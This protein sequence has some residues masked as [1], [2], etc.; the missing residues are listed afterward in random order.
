LLTR[1][2][3]WRRGNGVT[4]AEPDLVGPIRG[5]V[6]GVD[7]LA[8]Q[9][10]AV[11]RQQRIAPPTTRRG[12]GP[13]LRRLDQT[14]VVLTDINRQLTEA[15]GRGV[16]VSSAGEW[17]LD[18]YYIV[19]EHMREIRMSLPSRYYQEL[20]KLANGKLAGYPRVY[21]L[22]IELIGHTEG[23]LDLENIALFTGEYQRITSL[24]L[25]EL[26][27]IPT[28][29]RLGLVEN[30][31]RMA[32]RTVARLHEVEAADAAVLTLRTASQLS[33]EAL[34]RALSDFV[35]HHPPLTP[36][37]VAR[38]LSQIRSYQTNFTPL[39][40]LE[41]WIAEDGPSAE[42]AVTRS[43]RRVAIT[44][45]TITNSIQSLRMIARLDWN[46]FVESQSATE[47]LLREDPAGVYGGMAFES[48]DAYRHVV[49]HVAKDAK[50]E[51]E[52]VAADALALAREH[53]GDPRLGHVGYWLIETAGRRA[54]EARAGYVPDAEE[55][56]RRWALRHPSVI[57]FG[58]VMLIALLTIW[59]VFE[60]IP[61]GTAGLAL[62]LLLLLAI[63]ASEV[64]V[65][66]VNQLVTTFLPPHILAKLDYEEHGIPPEAQTAV[67]IPTL[68]GSVPVVREALEHLE[69]QY[70]ANPDPQL[71][72]AL[73]SDFTDARSETCPE[74]AQ[75][76]DAAARGVSHLNARYRTKDGEG[77]FLLLHRPRRWNPT[78]GVWMGW[79]R[80]RGK[81]AEFNRYLRGGARDAFSLVAGDANG[82]AA[83]RYVITLDSDTVLPRGA[84]AR[85]VG[86]MAHPLNRAEY[87][88][89]LGRVV[90]GYGILQPRVGVALT[91]AY[92]SKFAAIHSGHPG[93]DPYTTA[94]SDVYQDLY[95]EGSFTGKGIYDVDAFEAATHGRFPENTL[96]SHDLIEGTYSRA[97]L[98]TDIELYDDYPTR[99]LAYTRRKHRWIR[100][101]WQ[102]VRWLRGTVPGPDGPEPNRL[103]ALSRW[104]I[105]DN[106]RRSLLEIAQVVLLIA[107]W[108]LLPGSPVA[109]SVTVILFI[110]F[111]WIF[112]AAL[113]LLQPPLDQSWRAYYAAVGRDAMAS[114]EQLWLAVTF[115]PH[116]AAVSADAIVRTLIR[117]TVTH[118][119]LLEWQTASQV[120]RAMRSGSD[121][122][123]FRRMWPAVTFALA[124]MLVTIGAVAT[125]GMAGESVGRSAAL[126]VG[127]VPLALLW[128]LS[129]RIAVALSAPAI[130][131]EVK[132]SEGERTRALR[133]AKLHWEFFDHFVTAEGN[134]LAP[135]NFQEEPAPVIAARTSPTN[136]GL[137]LLSLV[138][139]YDLGFIARVDMIERLEQVFR[140]LERMQRYRGHFYNWYDIGTLHVLE[141]AYVSTVDSGNLAGHFIALKQ[142]C[143]QII[144]SL[145]PRTLEM[146][147]PGRALATGVVAAAPATRLAGTVAP[148]EDV[149]DEC[150]RLRAIADRAFAYAMEM[151]FTF[152]FDERRKLFSIGYLTSANSFDNSFY[153]LLASE[154][155]LAS[156]VAIAKGDVPVEHWFHLGRSLT[157]A[158]GTRAL[159]SWSGSMFEYLMPVLITQSY[160]FTLLD[161]TYHGAVRRQIAYGA[162]RHVP[163][164]VSESA[165]NMRDRNQT[166]Q[167]RA[168]GVPDLALKR[169]LSKDLVVAPYATMLALL[170]APHQA[171]RNLSTLEAAGALGP[172]GFRDAVDYTRPEP[173]LTHATV[174]AYMAHHIGMS[175]V[176][177]TNA[178]ERQV[179]QRRFHADPVVRST[180]LVLQ[181]RIPRRLVV[182]QT[183]DE[184]AP[185]PTIPTEAGKP[186]VREMMTAHTAQPR[187]ALLGNVPYTTMITNAGGG[188]S[189]YGD[190]VV[191]RWRRDTTRDNQGEWVYLKDLTAGRVW[192][193]AYQPVAV[194][195]DHYRVLLAPD[196]VEFFRRDGDVE[197]RMEVVV[198]S[199]DAAEV[200]RVTVT[201]RSLLPRD[202]ELTSYS[203]IVLQPL[204]TDRQHPAFG[205]LF[206]ETEWIGANSAILAT[207]RPRSSTDR[208]YWAVHVVAAGAERIGEV[209]YE[210]DRARFIGRGKSVRHPAALEENGTLSNSVGAPLDPIFSLRV[211]L[212]VPPGKSVPVSFTTFVA[213]TRE[214]AL[215]LADLYDDPFSARR[216]LDLSWA[217]AQAELRDL[218]MAPGDAAVYQQL[219]GYLMYPHPRLVSQSP[220]TS[221]V[222]RGQQSLWSLGVSGDHPIML[223]SI[224]TADGLPSV[225]QLLQAHH[226]W[227]LKGLTS[228]LVILNERPP[229]YLQELNDAITETVMASTESGLLDRP[230]GVFV[231]RTDLISAEDLALLRAMARMQVVC[232]GVGLGSLL[233]FPDEEG[234]VGHPEAPVP[235]RYA[236]RLS[237]PRPAP[238]TDDPRI[239]N[240]YG[241]FNDAG[242]YELHLT[243][244][245][246]PPAPWANVIANP[247]GGFLVTESGSSCTW[248][249]NSFFYRLTPWH[250]DPV[251]DPCSDSIY[252]RDDDTGD[253]WTA[254]PAPIREMTPYIVRHGFG[255][256]VFDHRHD[257]VHTELR[258]G[259]AADEPVKIAH[260]LVTNAGA[261]AK[262]LTVTGYVEWV[263]GVSRDLTQSYLHTSYDTETH[264]LFG[265]NFFD[266]QWAG[267][268]AF[269]AMSG[270]VASF[271]GDRREF[272]GRNGTP[273]RPAALSRAGLG[274][275]VGQL[276]DP[277]GALQQ[278]L[279]I[280]AGETREVIVLLGAAGSVDDVRTLIRK[281]QTV[282]TAR[283]ELERAVEAWR[284]RLGVVR[285]RTPDA[286]FD[287]IQNGWLLYQALSC[288]MWGRTALYQSSGAYG[289]R[290]QL[291][292]SMAFLYA[293]QGVAREHILRCAHRQFV[294]G[295]VQHWWH[296]QTG[297]GVRTRI[298]D[299]L[300]WLPYVVCHYVE[301]TGDTALLDE[302]VPYITMR[303]LAPDEQEVYDQPQQSDQTGSVYDH[304]VRA[305]R[306]ACTAGRHGLPL[307]GGG[308]WNDGFNRVGIGGQGESVWLAWFL[309]VTLERTAA[310]ADARGDHATATEFRERSARYTQAVETSSWDG[311]WYVRAYYDDGYPLGSSRSDEA[312]IDS[313]AQS[314]ALLS[315]A[316]Q[317]ARATTAMASLDAQLV[318]EDA[319]LIMLLTPA[320]DHTSHDP[321]YIKGYLPGVRENGAQYTHAATWA[322]WATVLAGRGTRAFELFR[323]LNPLTHSGDA[324]AVE[325]YKVEPYVVVADLYTAESHLG[326]GGWT[327]YTGS[328]SWLYRAGLEAI[329][330]F[331]RRADTLRMNPCIPAAWDGFEVE[332][333]HGS[334][335]YHVVVRNPDHVE[336]GVATVTLDGAAVGDGT[337]PL[338]DD[339]RRHEVVVTMGAG[340]PGAGSPA[341]H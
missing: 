138:S 259:M 329:L 134:W 48:R 74:D 184:D 55:R 30:I 240:G 258:V 243:G 90:R 230:G 28:M 6:L 235:P 288:R 209:T 76:L 98:V 135:D 234:Y 276:V 172:F 244:T 142:A 149:G 201:N 168:F 160:P 194:D 306:R 221:A 63:P 291:Q 83:T 312:K 216:A 317:P 121:R 103:S 2:L 97:G 133:Y 72:Y 42:E 290:D 293:E 178:L 176:A 180:E 245:E 146:E 164:G 310:V 313:I 19:Q 102:I 13:L 214:R 106:L 5:E 9:A 49:E 308:D 183:G 238:R 294:E 95:G 272:I 46:A 198:S 211:R 326:R 295:D 141:P 27:A 88:E 53:Q 61:V 336:R 318:R 60:A 171:L 113:A 16:D 45:V 162:E 200:R 332:Y 270:E 219:A 57:Y 207:R 152:L 203:E 299:D 275:A 262:R 116:Q 247:R 10:R 21:E 322:V 267:Q 22:A 190:I 248:A 120:E 109:W 140:S 289:F 170:V 181:E 188:F 129:P 56:A 223:A 337:V 67:V 163:W 54:L 130:P 292:D 144:H 174:G 213:E 68:F 256:S 254:T 127:T 143:I 65:T 173:G 333:A 1:L 331:T 99:Y 189:R 58:T 305:L 192:S 175:L 212:R 242:E 253:V 237:G 31:R 236:R 167:Y 210:T 284:R 205:N 260:L 197:T 71:R 320:F 93:V 300:V 239:T 330:G 115:L 202:I 246:L 251:R 23:R 206:V 77:P 14:R 122:E 179:W 8:E 217:Q 177:L 12:P 47:R 273:A 161:Q 268:I 4:P 26:W 32:L 151:D 148:D 145:R 51:E 316:A 241:F 222:R 18:N 69:V 82:L 43:N 128:L 29:L 279:T 124:V 34:S 81:L 287:R 123:V 159:V 204:D 280:P 311:E 341:A 96:L 150:T 24:R 303:E 62:T 278:S 265:Q 52:S 126:V 196:R 227:R 271:T 70:L 66:A 39:V 44:Q 314:W 191:T 92:R 296:P 307:I 283:T 193:A 231:R 257:E 328:A 340:S 79:E 33:S 226:Y 315:G 155:R 125:R 304:C 36:T 325:R 112:S 158:A 338:A 117:M 78:E 249:E 263:L 169:G 233:E 298:S 105:F 286:D 261:T 147:I 302:V 111:P 104:K 282:D 185:P 229:S 84:A 136:I 119:H 215:E 156:F 182:Q 250:N 38:F 232:D 187:I 131:G 321:G 15:A 327:W 7:R 11:A 339:G 94:V 228:D 220:G 87:D 37:F 319:Q 199:D 165:Y 73:L 41:Q 186:A 25:G 139:A 118:R 334:A 101:D 297:R 285:V 301:V 108:Y 40:W 323:M 277:C 281:Y 274:E 195:A 85:L 20:P 264:A 309:I 110:A 107:G 157:A 91:S 324:A 35:D 75:I 89:S 132:L 224:D 154:A 208:V 218:G 59:V 100:G 64:G 255:Y 137:Q 166:Y 252:L 86:T 225:R 3:G 80:K 269:L 266:E 153:D 114:A 335:T 50:R 17:L